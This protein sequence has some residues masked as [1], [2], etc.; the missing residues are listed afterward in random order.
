[1]FISRQLSTLPYQGIIIYLKP[2]DDFKTSCP[3]RAI[4]IFDDIVSSIVGEQRMER[5]LI[6][7][8]CSLQGKE[9]YFG[10]TE[11]ILGPEFQ[12]LNTMDRCD[13]LA[14]EEE[15]AVETHSIRDTHGVMLKMVPKKAFSLDAFLQDGIEQMK[16][17][18]FKELR[19]GLNVGDQVWVYRGR[20][21]NLVSRVMPY[22][23]VAVYVGN[24]NVVHVAKR[25]GCCAGVLMGTIKKVPVGD[26]IKDDDL[27]EFQKQNSN[28]SLLLD[29]FQCSWGTISR[30]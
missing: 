15:M 30:L 28:P 16:K 6:C 24:H 26:V 9:R 7:P 2:Q 19:Q 18:P 14:L 11:G 12:I 10:T 21:D 13:A 5:F 23:H 29:F 17:T 25:P 8:K 1:M 4:N 22:A 27:G 3:Y 20:K